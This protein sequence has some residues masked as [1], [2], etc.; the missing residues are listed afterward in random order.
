[1]ATVKYLL[2]V[3]GRLTAEAF[4]MIYVLPIKKLSFKIKAYADNDLL[5][6]VENSRAALRHS[7]PKTTKLI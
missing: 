5:P 2:I 6:D 4:T 3:L 7:N 1:M